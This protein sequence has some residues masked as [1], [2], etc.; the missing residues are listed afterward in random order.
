MKGLNMDQ[1]TDAQKKYLVGMA[2]ATT[3]L[4]VHAVHVHIEEAIK[5]QAY[6]GQRMLLDTVTNSRMY[7]EASPF[8]KSRII[9]AF[10]DPI[11]TFRK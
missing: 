1:F 2:F 5:R 11:H 9:A 10:K 6:R 3:L 7:K 8:E 4:I